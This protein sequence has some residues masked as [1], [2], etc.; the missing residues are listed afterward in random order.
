MSATTV[1]VGDL[2]YFCEEKDLLSIFSAFGPVSSVIVRRGKEGNSLQYAFVI[3]NEADAHAAC[4]AL[5]GSKFMGRKLRYFVAS[6]HRRCCDF[7]TYCP[8][9]E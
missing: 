4:N 2:S 6:L 9:S 3:M 5:N 8:F 7:L 1:F